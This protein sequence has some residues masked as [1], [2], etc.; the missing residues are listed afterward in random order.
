MSDEA[1]HEAEETNLPV[2]VTQMER[3]RYRLEFWRQ[4]KQELGVPDGKAVDSPP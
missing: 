3:F 4:R 1:R 2:I